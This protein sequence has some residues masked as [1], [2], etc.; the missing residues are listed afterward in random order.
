MSERKKELIL[1]IQKLLNEYKDE[2]TTYI[3]PTLLHYMD[4][5]ELKGIIDTLL[6]QKENFVETN[7][8]WLQSFKK[9]KK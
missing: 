6:S 8:E 2:S 9:I 1:D 5:N 3:N 4:E 7:S